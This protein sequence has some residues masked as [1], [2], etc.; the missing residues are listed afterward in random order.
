MSPETKQL[1]IYACIMLT[2]TFVSSCSQIILKK[3]ALKE[4]P[5]KLAEYL[6]A[7]VIIAYLIF[8]GATLCSV[9]AYKVVPLSVGPI[10][11][12]TGYIWVSILGRIFL[13]E[14]IGKRKALGL[15][16]IIAGIILAIV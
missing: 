6:N 7:P 10:L 12:A 14:H 9:T 5:N 1:L 11:E 8:F 4:Y 2:G 13:G 3:A 16:V 15:V